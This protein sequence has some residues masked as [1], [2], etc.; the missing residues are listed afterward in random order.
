MKE[1]SMSS[2]T[3]YRKTVLEKNGSGGWSCYRIP[4]LV[5][6]P[7]DTLIAYYETRLDANDWNAKNI[8][9]KRSQDGGQNWSERY[10]LVS[11]AEHQ[12]INNPVMIAQHSGRVHVLWEADYHRLFH[13]YSDD[14]GE[15]WTDP[16]EHTDTVAGF[17]SIYAWTSFGIGPGHGIETDNGY[18]LLPVWLSNGGGRAHRPSVVATLLS[19]DDG[20]TWLRGDVIPTRLSSGERLVNPNESTVIQRVDGRILINMRHETAYHRRAY[21]LS[22]DGQTGWTPPCLHEDLPDPVC[23]ASLVRLPRSAVSDPDCMAFSHCATEGPERENLAIRISTDEG[24]TWHLP[25]I[26]EHWAGYSDLAASPGGETLYCFYEQGRA[27]A[28]SQVPRQ[29]VLA[30]INRD[31][32]LID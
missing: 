11:K 5:V 31:S 20:Q 24:D 23:F 12:T 3:A 25:Q 10:E 21:S 4:G 17:R 29:L 1:Q 13:Q 6:T 28:E 14:E 16:V 26:I 8:G 2:K 7:S 15:T 19:K 32:L 22:N 30:T 18:L 9:I 27:H